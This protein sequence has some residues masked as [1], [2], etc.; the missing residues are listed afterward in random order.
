M[1]L[2][3]C[4]TYLTFFIAWQGI[5]A[6]TKYVQKFEPNIAFSAYL[7][8]AA[9]GFDVYSKKRSVRTDLP[10][11]VEYAPNLKGGFGF[12]LSYRA[13]DLSIGFNERL[14]P[15]TQKI[16]G[17]SQ[18]KALNFRFTGNKHLAFEV[19]LSRLQGFAIQ[20]AASYDNRLAVEGVLPHRPDLAMNYAKIRALFQFNPEKFSY[21]AAFAFSERQKKSAGGLFLNSHLYRKNVYS[22]HSLIPDSI[23][24]N[25]L[26]SERLSDIKVFAF[27]LGPSYGYTL[28]NG[29]W[30]ITP[31]L[32]LGAD[33]QFVEH[34]LENVSQGYKAAFAPML[35]FRFSMGYNGKR[36]FL[37]L[38]S[39]SD[40]N[41]LESRY[42]GIT[43]TLTR[44][45]LTL[46]YRFKEP[47]SLKYLYQ[48]I[49]K[50]IEDT[51][52]K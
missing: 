35:D 2:I 18:Y 27:G 15:V 34:K 49:E 33:I 41:V 30:F 4:I 42:F 36:F 6:Q 44:T 9:S 13:I 8:S 20:N 28:T 23:Q 48:Q 7:S 39:K 51:L 45:F 12:D 19:N 11:T 47:K 17:E 1:N 14:D 50:S 21:R 16:F 31:I 10:S 40:I 29:S 3:R 32:A 43:Y 24:G 25:F 37:A 52:R 26:F 38:S 46:G 5:K 22:T